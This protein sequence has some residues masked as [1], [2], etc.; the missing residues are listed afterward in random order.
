[1]EKEKQSIAINLIAEKVLYVCQESLKA[2]NKL[3]LKG[4]GTRDYYY[5]INV[6]RMFIG[7]KYSPNKRYSISFGQNSANNHQLVVIDLDDCEN[8]MQKD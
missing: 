2:Y 7:G 4:R 1:M 8:L 6:P 3:R 5:L